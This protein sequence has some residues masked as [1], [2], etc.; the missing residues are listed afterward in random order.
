MRCSSIVIVCL[1]L[2]F[3]PSGC[4]TEPSK[5][6][7]GSVVAGVEKRT[8][9]KPSRSV[10]FRPEIGDEVL[11]AL[12]DGSYDTRD[13]TAV[14]EVGQRTVELK[15]GPYRTRSGKTFAIRNGRLVAEK[16]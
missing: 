3:A 15:D 8:A 1:A 13:G 4:D 12:Q 9:S 16:R 11:V 14:I 5:A 10:V 7:G 6:A 2:L